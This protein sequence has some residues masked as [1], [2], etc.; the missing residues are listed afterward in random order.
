MSNTISS[1]AAVPNAALEDSLP[2]LDTASLEDVSGGGLPLLALAIGGGIGFVGNGG[3]QAGYD[4]VS[5][6][7]DGMACANGNQAMCPSNQVN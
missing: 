7:L 1:S 3:I 4:F 2:T 5:G 6:V